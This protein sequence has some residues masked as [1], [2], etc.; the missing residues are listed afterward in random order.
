MPQM[1]APG[2]G[3]FHDIFS[4]DMQG[5]LIAEI[6][7]RFRRLTPVPLNRTNIGILR[8][9]EED[10]D[11]AKKG[12]YALHHEGVV[13]YVGKTDGSLADRLGDHL[14]KIG[15]RKN[16]KP[17]QI[18]FR[19]LYLD[20]NWS[21][22]AH[23][24]GLIDEHRAAGGCSWNNN[25]FGLHDP[26]RRRDQTVLKQ[27]HF[28]RRFPVDPEHRIA[29]P[30]GRQSVWAVLQ[31]MKEALPYLL[32]FEGS[33][34]FQVRGACQDYLDNHVQIAPSETVRTALGKVVVALGRDWQVSFLYGYVILYRED[35]DYGPA[36]CQC[37]KVG[38]ERWQEY[39]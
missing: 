8:E 14:S 33:E 9:Y 5:V 1:A 27:D 21:A 18:L 13:A 35:T 10:P 32:R 37:R 19:C 12:L 38:S 7:G 29:L 31:A 30:T 11:H 2:D 36:C 4:L 15:G 34:G 22:L 25:G 24:S 26:G 16:I 20:R 6:S 39:A 17:E 23:E 28:D 3:Q